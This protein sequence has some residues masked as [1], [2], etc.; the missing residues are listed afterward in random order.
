MPG[1][2][3]VY[4]GDLVSGVSLLLAIGLSVPAFARLA[5]WAPAHWLCPVVLLGIAVALALYA[6][7]VLHAFR[8][9]KRAPDTGRQPFQRP[10]VYALYVAAG[11][12]FV[13]EPVSAHARDQWLETFVVPSAS[14]APAILPGDR[15]FADK[16]V[17]RSGGPKLERGAIVVFT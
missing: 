12:V 16:T 2:G 7:S 5:L 15:L 13:L 6:G 8:R 3:Q 10:I 17:G 11:Y 4:L 1:L 14:M 9:A